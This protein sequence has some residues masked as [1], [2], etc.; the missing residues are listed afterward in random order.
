MLFQRIPPVNNTSFH[1][2]KNKHE[3]G[4]TTAEW[5]A[6][7]G[8]TLILLCGLVQGLYVLNVRN[9]ARIY[10]HDAARTGSREVDIERAYASPSVA[11]DNQAI[12]ACE[13]RLK[14]MVDQTTSLSSSDAKCQISSDAQGR[15]YM[16][17][18]TGANLA[19][20]TLLPGAQIFKPM[21]NNL[22]EKYYPTEAAK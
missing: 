1:F 12:N 6:I 17:A 10:L 9:T 16:S 11:D 8:F 15:I 13:Y 22:N 18:T 19:N 21:L 2:Q 14:Q 3:S 5:I 4:F 7:M 20:V